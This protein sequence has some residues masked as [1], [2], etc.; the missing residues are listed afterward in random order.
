[1]QTK[2]M[3]LIAIL[4]GVGIVVNI[5]ERLAIQ[6]FTGVPFI[7]LGLANI[8]VLLVLYSYGMK[9]AFAV[10]I[11]RVLIVAMLTT[12]PG[13]PTFFLSLSG[14]LVAFTMMLTFKNLPGFSIISV[15]VMGAVGHAVGQILMAMFILST[16]EIVYY[17]PLLIIMSVPTGIFV[18][19]VT[20]RLLLIL[21]EQ[22]TVQG[23]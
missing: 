14:G 21:S 15:S 16:Q 1:M 20:K 22:L 2:K 19:L 3:I 6:G 8:V 11:L 18:G 9:D 23:Y 7:R 17:L 5:V 12:G 10:L 4:L 13:S